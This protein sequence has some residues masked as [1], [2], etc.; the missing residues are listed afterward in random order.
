MEVC[1][2][3]DKHDFENLGKKPNFNFLYFHIKSHIFG[4]KP[5][6]LFVFFHFSKI[7]YMGE[8]NTTKDF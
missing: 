3:F 4:G 8:L 6:F 1:G 5:M 2:S 7:R